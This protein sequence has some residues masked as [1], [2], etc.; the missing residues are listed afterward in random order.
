MPSLPAGIGP[1]M[2]KYLQTLEQI[3]DIRL[4]RRGDPRDRAVTLR[5]LIDSGLAQELGAS[6]YNPNAGASGFVQGGARL[7]DLAVPPAPTGFTAD[8]AFSQVHLNWNYPSYSNHSHTE[9]HSHTSDVI[10]DAVLIGIQTGRVFI[11][12]VGSGQTRYYWVRHVNTDNITGPFNSASGTVA[13]TAAD[14]SFLLTTLAG[15]ITSSEL[16]SDLFW[17][18]RQSTRRY[19]GRD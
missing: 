19:T 15:A 11:D 16:A 5:E 13:T 17:P 2:R 10:G 1:E 9:V 4:G 8:G 18:Y 6:P 3:L 14:V 12:P 7:Q